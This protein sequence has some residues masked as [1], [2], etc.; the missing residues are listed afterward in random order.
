MSRCDD[1]LRERRD[2]TGLRRR[3]WMWTKFRAGRADES[4][5]MIDQVEH[6]RNDERARDDA[7]DQRDLLLPGRRIE[8]ADRS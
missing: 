8:P 4:I 3:Q 5:G 7:E 6:R 2:Q 1:A